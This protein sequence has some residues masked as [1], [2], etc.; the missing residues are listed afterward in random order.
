MNMKKRGQVTTFMIVGLVILIIFVIL[1]MLRDSILEGIKGAEG[2]KQI[3][4]GVV[5]EMD[6]KIA[7][8]IDKEADS[9]IIT[10]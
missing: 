6:F 4:N 1:F 8:C 9:A 10:L 3:L 2:T 7:D 5:E